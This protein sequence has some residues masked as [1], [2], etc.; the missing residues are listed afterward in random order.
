MTLD[1]EKK[2]IDTELAT[3]QQQLGQVEQVRNQLI[4]DI[5][6]RQGM[7]ELLSRLNSKPGVEI[8]A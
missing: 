5:V 7:L 3:L 2:K 4:N 6:K 1:E 8:N